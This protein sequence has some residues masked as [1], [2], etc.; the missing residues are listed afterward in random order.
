MRLI[1]ASLTLVEAGVVEV[2]LPFRADLTQQH[3]YLHAG[4]VTTIADT[5]CGYAALTLMPEGSDVVS[6]EFKINLLRPAVGEAFVARA[7]VLRAGRS[8]TVTRADVFSLSGATRILVA[9]M[10]ATM[11]RVEPA[12]IS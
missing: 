7:S 1:G 4:V 12:S 5:A 11:M 6:V 10:Q 3:G 2:T 9:A 8:V